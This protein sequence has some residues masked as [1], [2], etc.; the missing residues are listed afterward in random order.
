M[1]AWSRSNLAS[2]TGAGRALEH[3][4]RLAGSK[5]SRRIRQK[6]PL[7]LASRTYENCPQTNQL[8]HYVALDFPILASFDPV[9]RL[10][11]GA[12]DGELRS[13]GSARAAGPNRS[14]PLSKM[15]GLRPPRVDGL[16]CSPDHEGLPISMR[17]VWGAYLGRR[18]RNKHCTRPSPIKSRW[19][20]S[21]RD[22]SR[23]GLSSPARFNS[24]LNCLSAADL[25]AI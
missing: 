3:Q 14:A 15:Q 2:L 22:F 20:L 1:R 18:T 13:R 16:G 11:H 17:W 25:C 7:P 23:R 19:D 5:N 6:P 9:K 10:L 12:D 21:D 24:A 8:T 4:C